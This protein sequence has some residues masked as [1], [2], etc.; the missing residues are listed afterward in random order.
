MSANPTPDPTAPPIVPQEPELFRILNEK[1]EA[2]RG[3]PDISDEVLVE[4]FRHMLRTRVF[5]ETALLFQRTGR[6]P[7][8]YPCAGQEAHVAIPLA[9]EDRDWVFTAYREQ[10]VRL[11]RGVPETNEL[12]LWRGMPFAF[13]DPLEFRISP[14]NATIGTH[15]P[16]ATGYGYGNRLLE[17]DEVALAVFGDGATS[18][19]DFHAG[20]NFSGVWM[21]PTVFFCQ[22]NQYAQSTPLSEQ[23]A[24]VTLAQKAEAYGFE[25]VPLTLVFK[26]K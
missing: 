17:R 16:H 3:L 7:A 14:L 25:G 20:L 8:Y 9:L 10:G 26:A 21:T 12:A 24:S 2:V 11:A 1:G 18:E 23:T 4:L 22:N 6:I 15:I 5:D 19:V 13:W